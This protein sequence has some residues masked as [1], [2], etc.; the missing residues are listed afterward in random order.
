MQDIGIFDMEEIWKDI[1]G[2]EGL[3]KISNFGRVWSVRRGIYRITNPILGYPCVVFSV[4]GIQKTFQVH[5]LVAEAFIPNP[6]DLP[7]VNHKDENPLNNCVD[8]LEWCTCEY[9]N[10]YGTR[11]QRIADSKIGHI[12]TKETKLK[13]SKIMK[14]KSF[15]KKVR[16]VETGRIF[17]SLNDAEAFM[18]P[19]EPRIK[20]K[21]KTNISMVCNTRS[22]T[23]YGYHW[24]FVDDASASK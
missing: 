6:L 7:Q 8:N 5:R 9:N 11:N 14:S 18:H 10:N 20:I 2:Y 12:H 15:G 24:E 22:K 4:D 21:T 1:E 23:A 19:N 17:D 13:L 16:C 3:Y